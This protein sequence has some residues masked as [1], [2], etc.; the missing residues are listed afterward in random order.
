MQ[1]HPV[2]G[3]DHVGGQPTA[4]VADGG[5]ELPEADSS[6]ALEQEGARRPSVHA[7]EQI[8]ICAGPPA[9]HQAGMAG[10]VAGA[11]FIAPRIHE[12]IPPHRY[13]VRVN[14]N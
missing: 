14:Y 6:R 2:A 8:G 4:G 5:E 9:V 3:L 7:G 13:V 12:V 1:H 11:D 10:E